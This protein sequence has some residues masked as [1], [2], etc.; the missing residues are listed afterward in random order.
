MQIQAAVFIGSREGKRACARESPQARGYRIS[1]GLDCRLRGGSAPMRQSPSAVINLD[2]LAAVLS[3]RIHGPCGKASQAICRGA[4]GQGR[5]RDTRA[6]THASRDPPAPPRPRAHT[7]TRPRL[8]DV[9]P[10]LF[11][12][13]G[14][15]RRDGGARVELLPVVFERGGNLLGR[16][17]RPVVRPVVRACV[18]ARCRWWGVAGGA[19]GVSAATPLHAIKSRRAHPVRPP[20]LRAGDGVRGARHQRAAAPGAVM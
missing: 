11:V 9:A 8:P 6:R 13:K 12:C 4:H 2:G 19:L 15:V 10:A 7:L 3:V 1:N 5:A 14:A 20:S 17:R 16:H 18:R